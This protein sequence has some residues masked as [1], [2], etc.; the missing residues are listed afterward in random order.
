MIITR[1]DITWS[2]PPLKEEGA[3]FLIDKEKTW[4][5]FDV[6]NKLRGALRH[7][8][9]VKKI[10]VGH[11][12]TLDPMATGLLVVAVGPFTKKIDSIQGQDKRYTATVKLGVTTPSYDAE[13]DEINPVSLDGIRSEDLLSVFPQFTGDIMQAPPL[14]SA[15]KIDGVRAYHLARRGE[16]KKIDPRPVTIHDMRLESFDKPHAVIHVHCSKG[17]YIRS[18]AHDMGQEMGVGG[19]LAD[20]RRTTIGDFHVD[21]AWNVVDLCSHIND[22]GKK[23]TA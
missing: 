13:S 7:N 10:K 22:I 5:S 17:T 9:G 15:V 8:L 12:G 4:T 20:L 21:R 3:F 11:A 18:L 6:V 1:D 14:F 16:H 23:H 2:L 19:Y